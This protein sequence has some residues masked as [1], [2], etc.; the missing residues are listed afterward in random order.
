MMTRFDHWLLR[1][2]VRRN[3]RQGTSHL[4]NITAIYATVREACAEEFVE[5]NEATRNAM[6]LERFEAARARA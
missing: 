1:K 4:S 5:D 6:L 3:V 2:I